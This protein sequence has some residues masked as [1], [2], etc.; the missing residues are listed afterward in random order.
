VIKAVIFDFCQTLVDSADG[1]RAAEKVV[2]GKL[3]EDLAL[4]DQDEFLENYRR[5][6]RQFQDNF[7]F[8]R[9][10]M[11]QEVY[12]YYCREVDPQLL[13][14]WES[15]YWL[16]VSTTTV[17]FPEVADVLVG[18]AGK[19]KL[20]L[21]TNT[22]TRTDSAQEQIDQ[23]PDLKKQFSVVVLA[24]K[25][26]IPAKPD[27]GAFLACLDELGVAPDEAVYVGD[28]W[29]I[30]ICGAAEAGIQPI[31]L[32][33]GSAVRSYPEVTTSVPIITSPKA[34]LDLESVLA[35]GETPGHP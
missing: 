25:G 26:D 31:W 23:F 32:Q 19:Y 16:Q 4:S 17:I 10:A 29:Q 2:Q 12:W 6:R 9:K 14:Q 1:F 13:E 11:W 8:S 22:D 35:G 15:E 34:L 21:V 7:R 30:D 24:G 28:D 3:F 27:K 33:H 5:I 18:L 20:G